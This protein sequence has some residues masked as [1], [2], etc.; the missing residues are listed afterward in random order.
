MSDGAL[1]DDYGQ[2]LRPP[3][4]DGYSLDSGRVYGEKRE[5]MMNLGNQVPQGFGSVGGTR[6]DLPKMTQE[7]MRLLKECNRESFWRRCK[8]HI[9]SES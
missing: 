2:P 6:P 1:R 5:Q 4:H 7:D 8:F 9:G 3:S